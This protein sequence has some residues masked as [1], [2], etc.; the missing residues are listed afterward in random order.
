MRLFLHKVLNKV[1]IN[2]YK[3]IITDTTLVGYTVING[4]WQLHLGLLIG[5]YYNNYMYP[6]S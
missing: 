3:M 6:D 4:S 5:T 1:N 2:Y